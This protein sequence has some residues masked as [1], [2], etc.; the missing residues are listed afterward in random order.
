MGKIAD[1]ENIVA[2]KRNRNVKKIV[3]TFCG[4]AVR[5]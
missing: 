3:N 4:H 1:L 2:F 5:T